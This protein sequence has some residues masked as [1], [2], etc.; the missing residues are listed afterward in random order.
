MKQIK[1]NYLRVLLAF[2]PIIFLFNIPV[3]SSAQKNHPTGYFRSPID[4]TPSLSGT[5]AEIRT[6]HFH[7]GIDYRTQS[8]EGKPVYAAADGFVS[9]IR[10]SPV[11]F[12][13]A[14]YIEHPNGYTTVYAHLRNFASEI[15]QYIIAEQYKRES[16]DVDLYPEPRSIRVKKGDVI[17]FSGNSGSSSGP[18]LHFEIRHTHNQN[19]VNPKLFALNIRDDIPP[20]MQA[21][22]IYPASSN[23]TIDG[24]NQSKIY[25]LTGANGKYWLSNDQPIRIAGDVAFGIQAYDM[26][27]HSNLRNGFAI[28]NI[29]IDDTKVF[30]Y[31]VDEFAFDETRYV[32]AV[33]D[34]EELIRSK[35]RFIQ[36]R[37][38]PNNPLNIYP[39]VQNSGIF[40]FAEVGNRV[41]KIETEDAAGNKAVLQFRVSSMK[42]AFSYQA[43]D[44]DENKILFRYNQV[45][46]F[47][48]DNLYLEIPPMALY[49]DIWFG[50]KAEA[51][52]APLI[53]GMH[54][55]HNIY[56]PVHKAYTLA[57]KPEVSDRKIMEKSV[58]VRRDDKGNWISE[59][60]SY[61]DGYVTTT[62]RNFGIFSVMAD[63]IPP[64]ITPVNISNNKNISQQNEVRIKIS[65]ALSGIRSYRGT[66]NGKW[67]LMDYDAKNELLVYEIDDRTTKG[68]NHF[69]LV[70]EDNVGNR[71]EYQATLIR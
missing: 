50:Y 62:T 25:E 71:S 35:R 53:A 41:V 3:R 61:K 2:M 8:V 65:D 67:I 68:T 34:Y 19:P 20:V 31:R 24:S 10:I 27:N 29:F 18:H 28:M 40:T 46:K 44:N 33:I 22:K 21:L 57:I 13:K 64:R 38:L 60:G 69:R 12:G 32:N 15:Q 5:F 58:I 14:I 7:S 56:T 42:P 39:L 63:T 47:Q 43:T 17:A 1:K 45:N 16:F 26:H 11:G 59:G 4:F 6:G 48:T 55:I 51:G 30:A 36:T 70:V 52:A 54:H 9:R 23:S 37:I 66:M 49:D